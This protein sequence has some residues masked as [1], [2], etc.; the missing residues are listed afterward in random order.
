MKKF[1]TPKFHTTTYFSNL[2]I[3][4]FCAKESHTEVSNKCPTFLEGLDSLAMY[5]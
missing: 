3:I 4:F 2:Q 5:M 1:K